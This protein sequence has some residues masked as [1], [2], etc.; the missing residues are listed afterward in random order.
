MVEAGLREVDDPSRAFL[1]EHERPAP[2]S[3]VAPTLEGS[4]P[5]LVEVQ[6]L[7]APSGYGTPARR[8]AASI[9]TG[10]PARRRPRAAGRHRARQP[11]RLREPGRRPRRRRAGTRPAAG[12]RA[13]RRRCAT[14][15]SIHGPSRSAKSGCSA[16]CAG[17]AGWSAG[18]A[19]RPGSASSGR[20]FRG[21]AARRRANPSRAWISWP[22]R[23]SGRP[24]TRRSGARRRGVA[25][26]P[27]AM[28]G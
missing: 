28:L 18:C 3:V 8:G 14:S 12:A 20:S 6:A 11:R 17:S 19:R 1:V 22:W 21:A 27:P 23:R 15:R 10:W 13:R 25:R 5:L 24:S 16:S 4:R 26:R 2:G 7:V 9:R